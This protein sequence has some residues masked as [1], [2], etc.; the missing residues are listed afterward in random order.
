MLTAPV[1]R[2][3]RQLWEAESEKLRT[4]PVSPGEKI[5]VSD[6]LS[7]ANTLTNPF[8]EAK[9]KSKIEL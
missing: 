4:E 3:Q 7:M 8:A 5:D 2:K 1:E 9:A 6:L